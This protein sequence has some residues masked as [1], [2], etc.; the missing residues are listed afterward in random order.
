MVKLKHRLRHYFLTGLLATVPLGLTIYAVVLL[1]R[2]TDN[3][4]RL[5]P[6]RLHPD[7]LFGFHIPGLGLILSLAGIFIVGILASN[8][9]GRRLVGLWESLLSRIPLARNIY[10]AIKQLMETLFSRRDKNFSDVVL[11]EY[12]RKGVWVIGFVTGEGSG[13]IQVKTEQTLINVFVPTTPNPTSGFLLFVPKNELISLEMSVEEG[14]KLAI[15]GGIVI[16][17]WPPKH[18]DGS[19]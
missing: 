13:E 16:P 6:A 4:L 19:G 9:V 10:V 18:S 2:L 11:V 12:P 8:L 3:A 5:L 15:S 1:V 14:F 17:P 7:A